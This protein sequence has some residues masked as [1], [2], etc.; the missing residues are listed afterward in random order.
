MDIK[1]FYEFKEKLSKDGIMYSYSGTFSQ[2]LIEEIGVIIKT[3]M[4]A[5]KVTPLKTQKI[6]SVFIEQVQNIMNFSSDTFIEHESETELREGAVAIGENG[7]KQI[8]VISGNL[9]ENANKDKIESIIEKVKDMD[10]KELKSFYKKQLKENAS[11]DKRS[12]GLGLIEMA[13]QSNNKIEY[14]F[15]PVNNEYSYFIIKVTF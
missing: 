8:Y 5:N 3:K 14:Y 15:N 4:S 6:F 11:L 9:I 7:D 10:K 13:K 2:G 1:N 12:A